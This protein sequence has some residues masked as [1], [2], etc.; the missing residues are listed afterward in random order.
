[1]RV[2][3]IRFKVPAFDEEG[4]KWTRKTFD[5]VHEELSMFDISEYPTPWKFPLFNGH[6]KKT[7]TVAITSALDGRKKKKETQ[8]HSDPTE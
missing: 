8:E 6:G 3:T 1:M 5:H 2:V 4:R 7:G